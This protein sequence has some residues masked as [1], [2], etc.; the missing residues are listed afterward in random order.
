[1]TEQADF[2]LAA[3]LVTVIGIGGL[4]LWAYLAMRKA[5]K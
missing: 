2:I 1:M 4:V 3:Y 5:E